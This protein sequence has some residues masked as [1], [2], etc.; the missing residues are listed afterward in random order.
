MSRLGRDLPGRGIV[1]GMFSKGTSFVA[2]AS[3]RASGTFSPFMNIICSKVFPSESNSSNAARFT[4][5]W[6]FFAARYP[7][8]STSI[9]SDVW[10]RPQQAKTRT[11]GFPEFPAVS[12]IT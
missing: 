6:Y 2:A 5:A 3:R 4:L 8:R 10:P 12:V 9:V 1:D 11:D 7:G